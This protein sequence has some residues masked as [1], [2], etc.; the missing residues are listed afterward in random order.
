MGMK[1]WFVEGVDKVGKTTLI[2]TIDKAY[3]HKWHL[4]D[5]GFITYEVYKAL[6]SEKSADLQELIKVNAA[7]ERR[8]ANAGLFGYVYVK[9][10]VADIQARMKAAG[11]PVITED[12]ILEHI[13]AFETALALRRKMGIPIIEIDTTALELSSAVA[14]L[15]SSLEREEM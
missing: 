15:R 3:V 4:K 9:A 2:R 11:E 7:L 5:R 14:F 13:R 6:S 12:I 10:S 1:I 8:M